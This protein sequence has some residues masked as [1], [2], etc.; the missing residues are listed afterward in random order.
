MKRIELDMSDGWQSV[1]GDVE[2]STG[3]LGDSIGIIVYDKVNHTA[4]AAQ[5]IEP[6]ADDLEGKLTKI[7]TSSHDPSQLQ[8]Y[9][10]GSGAFAEDIEDLCLYADRKYVENLLKENGL[11]DNAHVKSAYSTGVFTGGPR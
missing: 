8:I 6:K 10:T 5:V 4:H 1:K 11:V 2:L 7:V 3:F 9:I